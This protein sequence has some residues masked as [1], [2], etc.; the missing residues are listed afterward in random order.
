[1]KL[2]KKQRQWVAS[3]IGHVFQLTY[4]AMVDKVFQQEKLNRCHGFAIQQPSQNQHSC[5]MMDNDDAWMYYHDEVVKQIDL[6]SMLNATESI[7]SALG[8]KLG[9]SWKAYV[10]ELPKMPWTSIYLASL[11]LDVVQ[12]GDDLQ[13]RIL[14]ALY[15]GPNGLK[16]KDFG[17]QQET[18]ESPE[19]VVRKDEQPMDLDLIINDIQ[20]SLCF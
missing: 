17:D 5:L 14:Y 10:S 1:M 3:L 13:S 11:E 9:N 20:N 8:F 15:Y 2:K 7:C 12:Q 4:A 19:R 6:N 16:R 18:M